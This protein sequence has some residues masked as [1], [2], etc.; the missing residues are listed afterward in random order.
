MA[1]AL[2]NLSQA[3]TRSVV[4]G[5]PGMLAMYFSLRARQ[6]GFA[7]P[8]WRLGYEAFCRES[9]FQDRIGMGVPMN[10]QRCIGSS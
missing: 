8:R 2:S 9:I 1:R 4:T 7:P 5:F 10:L 6:A 3:E